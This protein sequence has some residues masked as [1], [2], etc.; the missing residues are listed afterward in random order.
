MTLLDTLLE[1][2]VKDDTAPGIVVIARDKG[3]KVNYS[4]AFSSENGTPYH[5]DTVMEISSMTKFPTTIAALQLVERGLVTLDEDI[6]PLLPSFAKQGVLTSVAEDGTPTVRER[7]NPITLRHLITHSSGAGYHFFHEGLGKVRAWQK[8]GPPTKDS[9]D[10]SFD[11]PLLFEPGEGWE[12]GSGLDRVGQVVEKLSGLSLEDYTRKNIW[13]PLG[14]DSSTFFPDLHPSIKARQVPMAY[15]GDP[16]GPAVE[17]PEVPTVATGLKVP[18]GGH[19]LFASMP[20]YF[21]ILYSLLMDDEK[22]LK[23][24]TTAMMF[25]PQLVPAS[26]QALDQF[27]ETP[28]MKMQFPSPPNERDYGLGGLLVVGDNH[29]YWRKGALMWGGAASLNWFIDRSTGVC[30]IFGAQVLP[31]DQRMRT[32]ID[33]FQADVY[34]RAGKVVLT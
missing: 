16:E 7:R 9:V 21:S 28:E 20:D 31:S 13:E 10:D 2:A 27:L 17:K 18:Y 29:E 15:R 11:L 26:K 25:Q 1:S 32:L 22:L 12:Y 8:K 4:K 19:G 33:A 34:R 6:S 24:E 30:G 5:L 14:A 23:K 3:G